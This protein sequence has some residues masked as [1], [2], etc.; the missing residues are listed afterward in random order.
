M[1]RRRT[2]E[3]LNLAHQIDGDEQPTTT[4]LPV[5][6]VNYRGRDYLIDGSKRI[7]AWAD[8]NREKVYAYVVTVRE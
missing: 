1:E 2:S 5:T 6:I 3:L 7:N 8:K 4:K